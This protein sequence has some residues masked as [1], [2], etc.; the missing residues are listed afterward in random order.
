MSQVLAETGEAV[1]VTLIEAGP[2][3][4]TQIKTTEN[5][6]Y[7][8]VQLGCGEGKEK[9]LTKPERGHLAKAGTPLVRFL[10]EIRT[11]EPVELSVGQE[12]K[13]EVFAEG[14]LVDVTGVSKGKGFQGVVKRWGF[15]RRPMTHGHHYHR[16]PGSIGMAAT[17][18][19]V[20]KGKKMPGR[21]GGATRTASRLEV[22]KVEGA[23]NIIAVKGAVPGP[24]GGY[25]VVK[26][27]KRGRA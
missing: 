5:D 16:A 21:M 13:A 4:V 27:T 6:G 12:L 20:I 19:R 2:C 17:P 23:L 10:T 7:S 15:S 22:V 26:E 24:K 11:E 8:A 9:H 1:P 18:S 3:Y 14:D 25:V